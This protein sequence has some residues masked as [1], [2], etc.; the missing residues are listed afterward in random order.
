M[1]TN[2]ELN[3]LGGF[4]LSGYTWSSSQHDDGAAWSQKFSNG[5]HTGNYNWNGRK[6]DAHSVRLVLAF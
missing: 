2:L 1:Y 4:S 5:E 3:G 6:T